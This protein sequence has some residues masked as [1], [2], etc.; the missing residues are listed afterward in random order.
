MSESH[1]LTVYDG[2]E[3]E[4]EPVKPLPDGGA[5]MD[6]RAEDGRKWRID[7][8]ANGSDADVVTT[9]ENGSLADL[10]EPEWL[11]DVVARLQRVG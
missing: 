10:D 6:I 9:W 1:S 7:I 8:P 4:V 2:T 11:G 3:I 5:R